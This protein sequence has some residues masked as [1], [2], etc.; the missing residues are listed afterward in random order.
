MDESDA[1][2]AQLDAMEQQLLITMLFNQL[3]VELEPTDAAK[4]AEYERIK[5]ENAKLGEKQY[6]V[7]HILVEDEAEANAIIEQ[8]N[9]GGDFAAIAK[10]Q[11]TDSGSRDNGGELGW[12]EPQRYVKPFSDAIVALNKGGRTE[13][14]VKSD[15]GYHVIEV[16]DVRAAEFP[17]Y[18]DV[19]EQ[20]RK[21]MLTKSRDD[22]IT[23]LRDDAK[24]EKIGS[25]DSK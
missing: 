21:E 6:L 7:R 17:P 13:K 23:K 14:P 5:A 19:E 22:L 2:K 18:E 11:S 16:I 24:I 8:L 9:A 20:L 10:E 3:I 12:A 4:H 25:L 15:Y 1:Y